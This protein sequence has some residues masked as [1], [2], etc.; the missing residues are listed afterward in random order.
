MKKSAPAGTETGSEP[1]AKEEGARWLGFLAVLYPMVLYSR[2]LRSFPFASDD[3]EWVYFRIPGYLEALRDRQFPPLL[4]PSAFE[5]AGYAFPLFYPPFSHWVAAGSTALVGSPIRGVHLSFYASVILASL[6]MYHLARTLTGS[7]VFGLVAA[8][9]YTALPYHTVDIYLRG[10][11]AESWSFVWYPLIVHA[12]IRTIREGRINCGFPLAVAGLI[13]S[14]TV[15]ALYFATACGLALVWVWHRYGAN[16]GY[17][18]LAGA[19]AGAGLTLWYIIPS[20]SMLGGVWASLPELMQTSKE[21]VRNSA[22]RPENRF[23]GLDMVPWIMVLVVLRILFK[24][25][26]QQ[27]LSSLGRLWGLIA[28]SVLF[29]AFVYLPGPFLWLLPQPFAYVQFSWRMFAISGFSLTLL[30]VLLARHLPGKRMPIYLSITATIVAL[31]YVILMGGG[32]PFG[33]GE[34]PSF[35][36]DGL[37]TYTVRGDYLP[38]PVLLPDVEDALRGVRERAD[39]AGISFQRKGN[40]IWARGVGVPG[41]E[42]VF[43]RFF[44]PIYHARDQDGRTLDIRPQDGFVA[45][46][47]SEHTDAVKISIATP[48]A[49]L[50]G[51]LASVLVAVLWCSFALMDRREHPSPKQRR[52]GGQ[53]H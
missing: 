46:Q 37:K 35:Q 50:W 3:F 43:P 29:T 38:R 10:A 33:R 1:L 48:G 53:S 49:L 19:L 51:L 23:Y 32:Q 8:V 34:Q 13:L 30:V 25:N 5:G 21:A 28:V 16:V 22:P 17:R 41:E 12:G 7:S 47:A 44:Y 24:E 31:P 9:M 20:Q 2:L 27:A 18:L 42:V 4:F 14:H 45:V 6:A 26:R 40:S 52:S 39:S 15:M 11:L 36:A